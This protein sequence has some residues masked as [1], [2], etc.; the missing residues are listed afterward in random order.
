MPLLTIM[1][2]TS[3]MSVCITLFMTDGVI[4][5]IPWKRNVPTTTLTIVALLTEAPPSSIAA[6]AGKAM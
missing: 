4:V 2:M 5:R 6:T 3:D 1:R